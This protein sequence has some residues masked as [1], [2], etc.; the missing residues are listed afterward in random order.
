VR[1]HELHVTIDANHGKQLIE[2]VLL[3]IVDR[4]PDILREVCIGC[5]VRYRVALDYYE[6]VRDTIRD[7]G[8]SPQSGT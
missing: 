2:R 1:Y 5:L 7:L 4:G 3:P 6:S 8:L